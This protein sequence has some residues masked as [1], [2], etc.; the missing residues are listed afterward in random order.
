MKLL[1]L[2]AL[3]ASL[4]LSTHKTQ[5]SNPPNSTPSTP[6]A[7]GAVLSSVQEKLGW[8]LTLSQ[9]EAILDAYSDYLSTSKK[10]SLIEKISQVTEL[11]P[12]DVEAAI[13]KYIDDCP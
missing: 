5:A 3:T 8:Y 9:R 2:T 12:T 6:N 11:S 1:V 4:V 7:S 10:D 13:N